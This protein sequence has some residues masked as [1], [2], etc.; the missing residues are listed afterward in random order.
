MSSWNYRCYYLSVIKACTFGW[1]LGG[2]KKTFFI[3]FGPSNDWSV[4]NGFGELVI[5]K[6]VGK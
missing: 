5:G 6:K 1:I 4:K 2:W 3:Q